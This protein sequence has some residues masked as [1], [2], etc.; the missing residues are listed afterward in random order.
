MTC[1][2]ITL[3]PAS[4][5]LFSISLVV[6]LSAGCSKGL[7]KALPISNSGTSTNDA[8]VVEHIRE[9]GLA[10]SDASDLDPLIEQAA[11]RRLVLLGEASHG[12]SEY[13]TWRADISRRLIEEHD[14]DFIIVEGDW[15]LAFHVNRHVKHLDE[16]PSTSREVLEH[17]HRW[18]LWMWGN[19][20]VLELVSWLHGHNRDLAE[21]ERAGFY[22]MDVYAY[23]QGIEDVIGYLE[24]V[25]A[26]AA[27]TTR[28]Y[29]SCFDRHPDM[30][31]YLQNVHRTGEHC[32][33][34]LEAVHR[35]L[36]EHR[37][38]YISSDSLGYVNVL[39]SSRMIVHAERHIRGNLQDGPQS[40]NHRVDH[41]YDAASRLLEHYGE[42]AQGIVWAHNTHI[43][44][45][46]ATAMRGSG[47][48]NIGQI[49]RERLGPDQVYAVGF[50]TYTGEVLA[51]R[52]WE[53]EMELMQVPEAQSGSYEDLM[54]QAG[55]SP[56]LLM[57]RDPD[58]HQPLMEPRGNRAIGVVYH[59]EQEGRG[60]Y[61]RTVLPL[62]Y[63]AFLFFE[64]TE[65]LTPLE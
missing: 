43:G 4:F 36:D 59:P 18:P 19:E 57:F 51:G 48:R 39:Q 29:Y 14:F 8:E 34:D 42:E 33:D 61:V 55:I 52:Q 37:E 21:T 38:A 63:N 5:L 20:E 54:Q 22:G 60:N 1:I 13:Y 65:A 12:T 49:A 3:Q 45:A 62:R 64:T 32:A 56:M 40:W 50:G 35:L 47:M 31:S 46:R 17:F 24:E 16:E 26:T 7:S 15:P 28:N 30:Q 25:D 44:D 11:E 23:E 10:V 6:F 53:G 58:T 2:R 27:R 9:H 41:F